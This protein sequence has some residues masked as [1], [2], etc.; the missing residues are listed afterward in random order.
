MGCDIRHVTEPGAS[1]LSA[2]L[3]A[4][5]R[6]HLK[7][8]CQFTCKPSGWRRCPSQGMWVSELYA[9]PMRV[10]SHRQARQ[11]EVAEAATPSPVLGPMAVTVAVLALSGANQWLMPGTPAPAWVLSAEHREGQ[12]VHTPQLPP[13]LPCR[14]RHV[15]TLGSS[16]D[17]GML[18]QCFA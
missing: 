10:S 4:V 8:W 13:L 15:A 17:E 16:A 14:A 5:L 12:V 1:L 3:P 11:V 2:Q 7:S 6:E 18:P 9:R